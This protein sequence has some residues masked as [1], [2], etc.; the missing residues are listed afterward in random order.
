MNRL[1]PLAIAICILTAAAGCRSTAGPDWMHPGSAE[2]QR[3]QALRYDPYPQNESGPSIA[4]A[5][6]RE[7]DVPPP[8]TSRARWT[9]GKWD[10]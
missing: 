10:Q 7:Y 6:P 1:G 4:G 5:R 2:A 9:L 3:K 8:E